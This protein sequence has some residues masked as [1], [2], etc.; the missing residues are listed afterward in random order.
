MYYNEFND[1]LKKFHCVFSTNDED[2]VKELWG[3]LEGKARNGVS[4]QNLRKV[5]APILRIDCSF[6]K[7]DNNSI[8]N[9]S[10]NIELS[11]TQCS[12]LKKKF[13]CFYINKSNSEQSKKPIDNEIFSFKPSI[14]K[15][16]EEL[17]ALAQ[18][19][20]GGI[21]L[22]KKLMIQN[23]KSNK[24]RVDQKKFMEEEEFNK[25][26]TF[27]PLIS[28][29][30]PKSYKS[31]IKLDSHPNGKSEDTCKRRYEL[32]KNPKKSLELSHGE[33]SDKKKEPYVPKKYKKA[34]EMSPPKSCETSVKRILEARKDKEFIENM[35]KKGTTYT[36]DKSKF[37]EENNTKKTNKKGEI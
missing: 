4:K 2:Y 14:G 31:W 15:K 28:K 12:I 20:L 32:S 25:T 3:I 18:Q 6:S 37:K 11:N 5:L 8:F 36:G 7:V 10:G 35:K 34:K 13:Y 30:N 1:F 26:C 21:S 24:W 16:T 17:A 33:I 29:L 22:E 27:H 19:R 23:E 9:P